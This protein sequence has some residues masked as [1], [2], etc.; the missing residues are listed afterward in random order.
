M[1]KAELVNVREFVQCN[2]KRYQWIIMNIIS[3]RKFYDRNEEPFLPKRVW[4]MASNRPVA[5][6]CIALGVLH[7]FWHW[8]SQEWLSCPL[9]YKSSS[10]V[11]SQQTPKIPGSQHLIPFENSDCFSLF[12]CLRY[13]LGESFSSNQGYRCS[14]GDSFVY[15]TK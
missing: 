4:R 13:D 2:R 14:E 7:W 1:D 3:V 15:D 8:N 12:S 11:K 10:S 6:F 5:F 9:W